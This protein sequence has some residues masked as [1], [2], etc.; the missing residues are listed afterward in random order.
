[1]FCGE[2]L[3]LMFIVN[4]VT[5]GAEFTGSSSSKDS[6]E[7]RDWAKHQCT[8]SVNWSSGSWIANHMS[9]GLNHQI[10]HH[11]F[12]SICHTNYYH[13]QPVVEDTCKEFGVPY[14]NMASF[15]EAFRM[16]RKH[17]EIMGRQKVA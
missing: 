9:G 5:E 3:A 6:K 17:L 10:E 16:M 13:I 14:N 12:P 2:L 1:M 15:G 7:V 11:L 4:H 8:T